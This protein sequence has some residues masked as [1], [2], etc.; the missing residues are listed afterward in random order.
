MMALPAIVVVGQFMRLD[1][2]GACDIWRLNGNQVVREFDRHSEQGNT[3]NGW[4]DGDKSGRCV[5]GGR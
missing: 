1:A 5:R 2:G 3:K 4:R